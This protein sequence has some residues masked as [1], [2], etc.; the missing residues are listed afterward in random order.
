MRKSIL[1]LIL[2]FTVVNL[3][4]QQEGFSSHEVEFYVDGEAKKI[5]S[6]EALVITKNDTLIGEF[7]AGKLFFPF[8]KETFILK[9]KVNNQALS[10]NEIESTHFINSNSKIL[11]GKVKK[12]KKLES[13][14]L[15]NNTNEADS[16]WVRDSNSFIV[17]NDSNYFIKVN[18]WTKIEKLI[19]VIINPQVTGT[20]LT[21]QQEISK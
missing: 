5:K 12:F 17:I 19:F 1:N 7:K 4:G 14:A 2:L 15:K 8:I 11:F 20:L 16:D 9:M 3:F 21:I 10:S 6:L 13:L 18:D